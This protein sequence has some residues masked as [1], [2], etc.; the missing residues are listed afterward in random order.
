MRR[1]LRAPFVVTAVLAASAC[2]DDASHVLPNPPGNDA[3]PYDAGGDPYADAFGDGYDPCPSADPGFGAPKPCTAPPG[4]VCSYLDLCPQH[5]A[6]SPTND[7]ACK[8]DGTGTHWTLVS[9][10]YV[11]D[12]P[13]T[14]PKDGDP[15]PC[16]VHY[17]YD[18]CNYG[19]CEAMTMIYAACKGV[20]TFDPVWHVKPITCNPPEPDA[21]L[22]VGDADAA[23]ADSSGETP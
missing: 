15:C 16:S 18:A 22:D 3:G 5:P 7:Y 12:C 21:S 11:P 2:G 1:S 8:T 23:E 20:D 10:P 9:D 14:Q 17:G 6:T 19:S 13:A 4:L